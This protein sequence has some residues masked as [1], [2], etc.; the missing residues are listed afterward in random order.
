MESYPL[1]GFAPNT[2]AASKRIETR[3]WSTLGISGPPP[4]PMPRP[5]GLKPNP[6]GDP[7][8]IAGPPIP[9]PRPSGLKQN[10]KQRDNDYYLQPPIPMPRP[11]GLKHKQG[12]EDHCHTQCPPI[13]TPRPSGLKQFR[14][15]YRQCQSQPPIPTP[16]P[17]GLKQIFV[18]LVIWISP[19]PNTHAA[20]KRGLDR[21]IFDYVNVTLA[22]FSV[23]LWK[24]RNRKFSSG[25]ITKIV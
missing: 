25:G 5:S 7:V 6:A 8:G 14:S 21:I 1:L 2:H 15:G 9:M 16:R 10:Q 3:L 4:I 11:S 12:S 23:T 24:Q 18:F 13:P 22:G 20:S 19:A 17:S